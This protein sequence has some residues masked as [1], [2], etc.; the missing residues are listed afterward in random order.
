MSL[1][2]CVCVCWGGGGDVT[3]YMRICVRVRT[4]HDVHAHMRTHMQN[5]LDGART[6]IP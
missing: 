2:M 6:C 5:N 1:Q 3:V 4:Q